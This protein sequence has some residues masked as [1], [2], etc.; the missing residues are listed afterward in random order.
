MGN[1]TLPKSIQEV[2]IC[3][4]YLEYYRTNFVASNNY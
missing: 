2:L 4:T 3:I 1:P